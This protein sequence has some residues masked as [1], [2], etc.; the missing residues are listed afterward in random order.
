M[1][2]QIWNRWRHDWRW[3]LAAM[4]RKKDM[5]DLTIQPPIATEA[6]ERLVTQHELILPT[7]FKE[8]L[9]RFSAG[10]RLPWHLYGVPDVPAPYVGMGGPGELWHVASLTIFKEQLDR[11]L[12]LHCPDPASDDDWCQVWRHKTPFILAGNGDY[13]AFDVSQVEE[14]CPVVYLAHEGDNDFNG[15]RLGLDFIDFVTRWSNL[16]CPGP[17]SLDQFHDTSQNLLMDSGDIVENW[18]RWLDE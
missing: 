6:L 13:V 1:D 12:R 4:L 16:G 10:V 2:E 3:T 7:E 18:K 8:V 17:N 14:H 9:T 5:L 11:V 15:R